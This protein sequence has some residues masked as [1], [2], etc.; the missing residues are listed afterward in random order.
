V[1]AVADV[2]GPLDWTRDD[3]RDAIRGHED[4]SIDAFGD[5]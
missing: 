5:D 2:L 4:A 1:R 3:V